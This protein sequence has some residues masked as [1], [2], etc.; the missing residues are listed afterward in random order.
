MKQLQWRS[1]FRLQKES[2]YTASFWELSAEKLND[3]RGAEYINIATTNTKATSGTFFIRKASGSKVNGWN[4]TVRDWYSDANEDIPEYLAGKENQKMSAFMAEIYVFNGRFT[5]D[6]VLASSSLKKY[7]EVNVDGKLVL[8]QYVTNAF[9]DYIDTLDA[10]YNDETSGAIGHYV[11][12]LIPS[13]VDKSGT[14]Q[15]LDI[16][17]NQD[18][19]V[20]NMMMSFNTDMLYEDGTAQIDLS[21]AYNISTHDNGNQHD[22]GH[23]LAAANMPYGARH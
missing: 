4:I 16:L 20:H 17:F 6:Q 5:A 14:Y 15:S 18:Q 1:R 10:L 21:G 22:Q 23:K 13:L 2:T 8:K 11:G 9:G 3:V 7:F 12:S 19:S